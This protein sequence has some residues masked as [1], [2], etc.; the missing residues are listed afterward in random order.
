MRRKLTPNDSV[1]DVL[2]LAWF[3]SPTCF[4]SLMLSNT[5][6]DHAFASVTHSPYSLIIVVFQNK[7]VVQPVSRVSRGGKKT[8]KTLFAENVTDIW[9]IQ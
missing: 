3:T 1:H 6:Y 9:I 5:T 4:L 8:C 7:D 2:W